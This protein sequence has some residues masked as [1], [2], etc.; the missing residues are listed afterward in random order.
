MAAGYG[1]PNGL[2]LVFDLDDTLVYTANIK[3]MLTNDEL[4]SSALNFKILNVVLRNAEYFR[5]A[6]R[7]SID[8]ILLLTN[9]GNPEYVS[10]VCKV[11]AQMIREN[12][13]NF[14]RLSAAENAR[15]NAADPLFFDYIMM[16]GNK[17]R[18]DVDPYSKNLKLVE[19]MLNVLNIS[20][21]N[22][23]E[24]TYFFDDQE[25]PMMRKELIPGHYIDIKSSINVNGKEEDI[26]DYSQILEEFRR[27]SDT[28]GPNNL[29]SE[30]SGS[31]AFYNTGGAPFSEPNSQESGTAPK[32]PGNSQNSVVGGRRRTLKRKYK[33]RKTIRRRK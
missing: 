2:V 15:I 29:G 27:I 7:G 12:P 13:R 11:I 24:R 3:N 33:K 6:Y 22:L 23:K 28:R 30:S 4:I 14:R 19:R 31:A 10:R 1:P 9:N 5:R 21:K 16:V 18:N 20:N 17:H 26:T 32:L 25:H 8:A